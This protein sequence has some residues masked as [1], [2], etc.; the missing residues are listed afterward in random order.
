MKTV[1]ARA[2]KS[3]HKETSASSS[4]DEINPEGFIHL[5]DDFSAYNRAEESIVQYLLST[6]PA[7]PLGCIRGEI[8][9]FNDDAYLQRLLLLHPMPQIP[10]PVPNHGLLVLPPDVEAQALA[11]LEGVDPQDIELVQEIAEAQEAF[12]EAKRI[13][14]WQVMT[15]AREEILSVIE[16]QKVKR[17]AL[18]KNFIEVNPFEQAKHVL[19]KKWPKTEAISL[20][21]QQHPDYKSITT[22][23]QQTTIAGILS[24][25]R[26]LFSDTELDPDLRIEHAE[27]RLRDVKMKDSRGF[28]LYVRN[29]NEARRVVD[30]E[31]GRVANAV[32]IKYFRE[33]MH[34]LPFSEQKNTI[35]G[36]IA[37]M[38]AHRRD[39][40]CVP[41]L[42]KAQDT[43]REGCCCSTACH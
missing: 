17:N 8:A 20:K 21:L 4:K 34:D 26:R 24:I 14:L 29:F 38:T 25:A 10:L 6:Y 40:G 41:R 39:D 3:A 16:L 18:M 30:Q 19:V 1:Q 35:E 43:R 22:G 5:T 28:D 31:G 27:E 42:G 23:H 2:A 36:F 11:M 9:E 32:L 12:R 7:I 15:T 37:E 33:G 13:E